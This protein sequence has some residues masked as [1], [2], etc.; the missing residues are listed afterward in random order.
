MTCDKNKSGNL[1]AALLLCVQAIL[2]LNGLRSSHDYCIEH[3]AFIAE[4]LDHDRLRAKPKSGARYEHVIIESAHYTDRWAPEHHHLYFG[5]CRK[6]LRTAAVES[7]SSRL[8]DSPQPY[9]APNLCRH[10]ATNFPLFK[11]AHKTSP[12]IMA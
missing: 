4:K 2:L 10:F 8:T 7:N 12:P 11:L 3:G 5:S 6:D 9:S 1:V